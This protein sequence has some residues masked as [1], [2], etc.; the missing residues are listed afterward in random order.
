MIPNYADT[1]LPL[2]VRDGYSLDPI[3]KIRS[4]DM[5]V[6]RAVQRWEFDD[7]PLFVNATWIF[8]EPQ[9]RLFVAWTN[10]V[11][12]AGWFTM[13]LVTPMGFEDLTVRLKT[14]PRR[15]ELVA[16]YA[17][18]YEAVIEIE[19]EP[20]LEEG[21]AEILP[22]YVLFPDIFDRAVNTEW[23]DSPYQTYMDVFDF[24]ANAEWPNN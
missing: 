4:T 6:G 22:E 17:W 21:W 13:R 2:P 15:G 16:R 5:D 18:R 8:T 24:A 1:G 12:K 7:A 3:E 14:T 11:V 9:A 10:Q 23:P 20:M 19:F